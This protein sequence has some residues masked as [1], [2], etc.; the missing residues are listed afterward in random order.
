M[1]S[2]LQTAALCAIL[3]ACLAGAGLLDMEIA[4]ARDARRPGIGTLKGASPGVMLAVTA[5]GGFRGVIVDLLWG[6]ASELQ[7]RGAYFEIAQ[8]AD[9][10]T[11]LEPEFT[12][13]WAFHAWN[14]AYNISY[15]FPDERDRWRWVRNGI[16]LLRDEGLE[17]NSDDAGLCLELGWIYQ[18]KIGGIFDTAHPYF[19]AQLAAEMH[20][21]L[22]GP[23]PAGLE[24]PRLAG[25]KARFK[26]DPDEMR[27]IDSRY[28]PLDWRLPETHSAYWALQAMARPVK[29]ATILSANR[30]LYQSLAEAF[31]NGRLEFNPETG[32]YATRPNIELL[33]RVLR[34]FDEALAEHDDRTFH[35]AYANFMG[36]AVMTLFTFN[37]RAAAR[38]LYGR[39]LARYP[40]PGAPASAEDFIYQNLVR[41]LQQERG[42]TTTALVESFLF[43]AFIQ[44]AEGEEER[45][46]GF[47][48]LAKLLWH[49]HMKDLSEELVRTSGLPP[50]ED[51]RRT[52]FERALMEVRG[53]AQR[54]RLEAYAELA[55]GGVNIVG[56]QD[57]P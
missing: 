16:S 23:G 8:L 42:S 50:L 18:H 28:G 43:Q 54:A 9:W 2:R 17:I 19:R 7:D 52:A 36:E 30:M 40:W 10:I 21:A 11:K 35:E 14:M 6:R 33:P 53:E 38:E 5:L 51:L 3:T 45:A 4:R 12:G 41:A 46:A 22:G 32:L 24:G 27:R 13:V 15:M 26:L 1:S 39:M 31:R 29:G 48:A 57:E 25:F 49:Q 56:G 37:R 47:H 20:S 55:A 34:A 44:F